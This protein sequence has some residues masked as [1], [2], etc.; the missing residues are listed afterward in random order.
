MI[1][2]FQL[3]ERID[4]TETFTP[5]V[6]PI[7]YQ[8]LFALSYSII[9]EIHQMDVRTVF[10]YFLIEDGVDINQ[11]HDFNEGT[12]R[13]CRLLWAFYNFKKSPRVWYDTLVGFLKAMAFFHETQIWVLMLSKDRGLA[14]LSMNFLF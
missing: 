4:Y 13:V 3:K 14:F 9:W 11:L 2:G 6:K 10:L 7:S 1:R 12:S 8:A 5:V